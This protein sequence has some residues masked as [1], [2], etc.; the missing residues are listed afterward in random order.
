MK[1]LVVDVRGDGLRCRALIVH[2][3]K[4]FLGV[5]S[6]SEGVIVVEAGSE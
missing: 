5:L 4:R 3:G 1:L 6:N 2:L